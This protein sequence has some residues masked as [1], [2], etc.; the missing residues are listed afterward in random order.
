[1]PNP[2][3]FRRMN[4]GQLF[5]PLSLSE[6]A[7]WI[8]FTDTSTITMDG[9]N[10]ISTVRSKIGGYTATQST[11]ANKPTWTANT[12]N[13]KGVAAFD[14]GD[15]LL[16]TGDAL[17]L[18]RNVSQ[19][20][21]LTVARATGGSGTARTLFQFTTNNAALT[22]ATLI[23]QNTNAFVAGGR[24][25]DAD[26]AD[27]TSNGTVTVNTWYVFGSANN[28]SNATL[29]MYRN[30][31][32]TPVATDNSFLTTGSTS[33]TASARGAIGS[34]GNGGAFLT[35]QVAHVFLFKPIL[36][37]ANRARLFG[38]IAQETAL[39]VS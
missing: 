8:D 7:F 23:Y 5:T 27:T 2:A 3:T 29:N 6:L 37:D 33:D 19:Y 30:N 16:L 14:G 32:I 22:R 39:S 21:M 26:A 9:S 31:S 35:G 24:R 38:W 20:E 12:L 13:G 15:E 1:M 28:H 36:S 34:N 17:S 10:L 4:S 18:I 25:L 11:D